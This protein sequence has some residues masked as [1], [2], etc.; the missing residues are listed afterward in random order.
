MAIVVI[1]LI[2]LSAGAVLLVVQGKG[3][4]VLCSTS[5]RAKLAPLMQAS[6]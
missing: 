4:W 1:Y 2:L 5:W 6:G 3:V